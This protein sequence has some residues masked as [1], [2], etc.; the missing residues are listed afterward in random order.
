MSILLGFIS[1]VALAIMRGFIASIS[2]V[3]LQFL[4]DMGGLYQKRKRNRKNIYRKRFYWWTSTDN[5][6]YVI[7][8]TIYGLVIQTWRTPLGKEKGFR[9]INL[10]WNVH[11]IS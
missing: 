9:R 5:A 4:D 7:D 1:L 2:L 10:W 8:L 6:V 11:E 3:G